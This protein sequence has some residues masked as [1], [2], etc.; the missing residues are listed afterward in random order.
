MNPV[1][2]VCRDASPLCDAR[3]A[4]ASC[5]AAYVRASAALTT[6]VAAVRACRCLRGRREGSS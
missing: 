6:G 5:L 3:G 4:V 2:R 1:I